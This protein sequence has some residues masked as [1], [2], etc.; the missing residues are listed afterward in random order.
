MSQRQQAGRESACVSSWVISHAEAGALPAAW[1]I[2]AARLSRRGSSVCKLHTAP[3]RAR[4]C[5]PAGLHGHRPTAAP[6]AATC[7][8]AGCCGQQAVA[9]ACAA[10]QEKF[11]ELG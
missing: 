1:L 9:G 6:A 3:S 5:K 8:R 10:P 4:I 7:P 2:K 11:A